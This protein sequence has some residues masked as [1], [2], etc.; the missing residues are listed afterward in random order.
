MAE[1]PIPVFT[2]KPEVEEHWD[3]IQEALARVL[4]SGQ[5]ILG[6]E[7]S[8]FE[9]EAAAFLG[10]KYAIGV[11]SGTDA[12][13]IALRAA[14]VEPGDEVITSPFSFFASAESIANIGAV[15]IFVDVELDS[16]NLD[17]SLLD[18]VV[19]PRTKAIMP[20]HLF[21]R[22]AEMDGVM[23]VAQRHG[24]KVIEDCAQS[25]GAE[26]HGARGRRMTG[27][28]GELGAFSFFP[29]KNLGAYGDAGLITTDDPVMAETCQKLRVHGSIKRYHNEV[30]GYN[31]RLDA[32]QAAI[33]RLKLPL[34]S[35]YNEARRMIAMRYFELLADVPN[36]IAPEVTPGHVFHQYTVRLLNQDRDRVQE[37]MAAQGVSTM[38]YY[39]IPQDRLPV[40]EGK[41]PRYENNERLAREVLSLPIW[42]QI[43]LEQQQRVVA[44]LAVSL[45]A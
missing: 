25:F 39:P 17:P 29:T 1:P 8:A 35:A 32:I 4:R 34:T 13:M 45:E 43:T 36:V 42:P 11:N 31:S 10:S 18:A 44:A 2:V 21:G 7:V 20:V 23:E 30:L 40:F 12:L 38:V 3:Q 19:T 9:A 33:L 14:G 37:E 26:H 27:T 24:L 41:Y 6:P 28:I 22:P 5:F 15:P 16:M